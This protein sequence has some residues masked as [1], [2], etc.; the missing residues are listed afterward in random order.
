MQVLTLFPAVDGVTL[1][2][3]G[4]VFATD[5]AINFTTTQG[6]QTTWAC[7]TQSSANPPQSAVQ[8]FAVPKANPAVG[9][10]GDNPSYRDHVNTL[11]LARSL[12]RPVRLWVDGCVSGYPRVVGMFMD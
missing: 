7:I 3:A 9:G 8:W 4:F 10:T 5:T 6:W 11:M 1:S 2:G 12:G